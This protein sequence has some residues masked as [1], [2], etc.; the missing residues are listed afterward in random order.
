MSG[1]VRVNYGDV[2]GGDKTVT[3]SYGTITVPAN[4]PITI[5]VSK[6]A[7]AIDL[8]RSN[9]TS[10]YFTSVDNNVGGWNVLERSDGVASGMN[11]KFTDNS[12]VSDTQFSNAAIT[13]VYTIFYEE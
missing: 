6:K 8:V 2:E 10:V 4:T 7:K 3:M 1:I 11:M 12:I 5:T 9:N 13:F